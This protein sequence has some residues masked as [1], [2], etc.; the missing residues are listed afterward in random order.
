M[1]VLKSTNFIYLFIYFIVN[2]RTRNLCSLLSM[3]AVFHCHWARAYYARATVW[4]TA[5]WVLPFQ[6]SNG[7]WTCYTWCPYFW[8]IQ[9]RCYKSLSFNKLHVHVK[10]KES[11]MKERGRTGGGSLDQP[12]LRIGGYELLIIWINNVRNY[13]LIYSVYHIICL[14]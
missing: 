9:Q 6:W 10:S 14:N 8:Q 3:L 11:N 12:S 5:G 4:C 2:D 7:M 1:V 13:I